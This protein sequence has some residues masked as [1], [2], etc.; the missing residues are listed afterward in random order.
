MITIPFGN[1][2]KIMRRRKEER[3]IGIKKEWRK[4]W[5]YIQEGEWS[6]L[7][8]SL[9]ISFW[10]RDKDIWT[11]QMVEQWDIWMFGWFEND[12]WWFNILWD[13]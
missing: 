11:G 3:S 5:K 6:P 13:I 8:K 7:A 10:G 1:K 2:N 4:E 9:H 12:H